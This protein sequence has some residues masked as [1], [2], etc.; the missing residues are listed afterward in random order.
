MIRR[1]LLILGILLGT[2]PGAHAVRLVSQISNDLVEITSSYDGERLTFFGTIAPEGGSLG[3]AAADPFHVVVVVIGPTQ[4][5]VAR[6]MTHNFGVWL[7]TG[8]VQ[9]PHF[10]SYLQVLSSGRL[11]EISDVTTLTK[12]GI[13]PEAYTVVPSAAGWLNTAV[14]GR[15]LIRLMTQA[16]LVGVNENGVNFLS[17][18]FYTARLALPSNAPPGPYLAQTYVFQGGELL[19]R[20]TQGFAVRKTGIERTI[21]VSAAQHPLIYGVATVLLALVTGWLGGVLFKR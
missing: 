14:F 8:E 11:R 20:Q 9:F 4:T 12:Q 21:A 15:E 5:R 2:L 7:N 3:Q 13:L 6:Q 16:G 1:L 17:D 18:T 10:P 19:A